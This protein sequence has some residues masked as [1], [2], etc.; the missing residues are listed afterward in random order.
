[1]EILHAIEDSGREPE[2][3][4]REA[5][6]PRPFGAWQIP[7]L[8]EGFAASERALEWNSSLKPWDAFDV[9]LVDQASAQAIRIERSQ[10]QEGVV[11]HLHASR[12]RHRWDDE[13]SLAAEELGAK[14][15]KN[16]AKV[17]RRL[18]HTRHG[19]EWL[20]SRWEGLSRVLE[21]KGD[22]D[23][24]QQGLA[25]D[26]LGMPAE[27]RN[28]RNPA[29][30]GLD[31]RNALIATQLARLATK[32]AA[33]LEIDALERSAAEQGFG[34]DLD[35][36]LA[37][38]RRQERTCSLRL[39]WALGLLKTK[40][41]HVP[42]PDGSGSGAGH[43]DPSAGS[44]PHPH[45]AGPAQPYKSNEQLMAETR[46]NAVRNQAAATAAAAAAA[47]IVSPPVPAPR[48]DE[49]P[50]WSETATEGVRPRW[51]PLVLQPSPANRHERRAQVA[52][53]RRQA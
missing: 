44:P 42:R 26:L 16:P 8:E 12:A 9:F 50:A 45:A 27:L 28:G 6:G 46:A 11:R 32:R 51:R 52:A 48:A 21:A 4:T 39:E 19:C 49:P 18:E 24:A 2:G 36:E 35:G 31:E 5:G 1:M 37:A 29:A 15:P 23:E 14:L 3:P 53:A 41:H 17:A 20:A 34:P 33:S 43:R 13:R 30:A 40:G 38:L 47:A 22:W 25:L 7:P 10:H